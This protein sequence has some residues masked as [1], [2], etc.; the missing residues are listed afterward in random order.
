MSGEELSITLSTDIPGSMDSHIIKWHVT[1]GCG[2]NGSCTSTLMV[3]DNKPPTPYC[4]NV[5]TALMDNGELE[6]WACDFDLGSFDNC[7]TTLKFTFNDNYDSPEDDPE[8]NEDTKCS[9]RLFTCDDLPAV[10]GEPISID[11]YVWD[12]KDN[13]DYCTVTLTLL[14]NT[15]F[16]DDGG[17]SAKLDIV[18]KIRTHDGKSIENVEVVATSTSPEFP[19]IDYTDDNGLYAFNDSPALYNYTLT[20]E[21]DNDYLNGVTTL[22]ILLMQKHVLGT[23]VFDTPY[24]FIAA[25]INSDQTVSAID[26]VELRKLILGIY[27]EF[28]A[29][30]SWRF[31]DENQVL[32]PTQPW[33]FNELV[34]V[35]SL[36]QNLLSEDFVG[37]KIG[38]VNAS[39]T[40][41]FGNIDSENR[42][43]E[44]IE[45]V[46]EQMED[47][48]IAF[49][50][51]EGFD[52]VYG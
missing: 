2:N 21:L 37:V 14:D 28:P 8:Y 40:P 41:N 16:C 26:L 9:S 5:S 3:V 15:D 17:S 4:L 30:K 46:T 42:S 19:K 27:P 35:N 50:A 39:V 47:G 6:L 36:M 43:G 25:D 20:P 22:D 45:F 29:N 32:N 48:K 49:I 31:V 10:P 11:I 7:S 33:P 13:Y 44:T 34:N 12:D 38:D 52:E 24:K 23:Q 51:G 1:D 18:G